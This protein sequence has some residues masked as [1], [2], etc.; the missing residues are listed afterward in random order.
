MT[1]RQETAFDAQPAD[2]AAD[3]PYLWLEEIDSPQARAWVEARNGETTAALCDAAFDRDRASILEILDAPDRIPWIYESG[4]L[5]YNFWQDG[6]HRKGIWRRTTLASYRTDNP[7]WET[8]LDID[9]LAKSEG[10]DWVWRGC[11]TLP[12]EHRH[13]LVQLSRGGADAVVMREFDLAEKRFV[14]GGFYLPE[15]KGNAA[16]LDPDTILVSSALGGEE[17]ETNS[18]YPRTVRRYRRGTP[19]ERD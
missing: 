19:F 14:D 12:P 3:D 18:G 17:F 6:E 2:N 1:D 8:L 9:L 15:A 7:D 4:P 13:G 11:S 5:V 10:E 16:W